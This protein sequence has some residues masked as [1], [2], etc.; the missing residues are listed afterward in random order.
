M[1]TE[2]IKSLMGY[3][4]ESE[5]L[6][7][8]F[9]QDI[10]NLLDEIKSRDCE[11]WWCPTSRTWPQAGGPCIQTLEGHSYDVSSVAVGT[12][13]GEAVIVS[14]SWDKTVKVWNA[15]TGECIKTLEGHDSDVTS[16]AVGISGGE[17][18]VVS[19][20]DDNTVKVW[21][22]ATGECIQTLEG[23]DSDVMC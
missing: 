16:V 2:L 22:A 7:T 20:S 19:G 21:N 8:F 14:G 13:G 3:A 10:K 12:V 1:P 18:V 15:V 9:N 11:D 23:H 5:E 6:T 4:D 17:A